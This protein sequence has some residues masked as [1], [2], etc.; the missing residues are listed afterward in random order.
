MESTD[1]AGDS[2]DPSSTMGYGLHVAKMAEFVPMNGINDGVA[3]TF[4]SDGSL[5]VILQT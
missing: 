1:K 4:M 2:L 3:A 5:V